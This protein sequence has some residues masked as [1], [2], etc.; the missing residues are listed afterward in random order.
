MAKPI[1]FGTD[2]WR[3]IIA[4]EYTFDNVRRCARG[5]AELMTS[6]GLAER[7]VVVG[8]D[9]RFASEDFAAAAAEALAAAGVRA[10]PRPARIARRA[11]GWRPSG[12][13]T[14]DRRWRPRSRGTRRRH[15]AGRRLDDRPR[16]RRTT[17]W[18]G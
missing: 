2:G 15:Y 16:Q 6:K 3:A 7:G 5:V 13:L 1:V 4:D 11:S 9:L 8:Y 12:R 18:T 17:R 10:L 14:A